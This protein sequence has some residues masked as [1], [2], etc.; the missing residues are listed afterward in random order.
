MQ[1]GG[2]GRAERRSA[3][4]R[5]DSLLGEFPVHKAFVSDFRNEHREEPQS[6][7]R[8]YVG[9]A[10]PNDRARG[11]VDRPVLGRAQEERGTRLAA[12]ATLFR[13]VGTI[14]E[15]VHRGLVRS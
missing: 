10:V 7:A 15:R 6:A 11:K 3:D 8:L 9:G 12:V 5:P 13:G 1:H 4:V 14:I 2:S